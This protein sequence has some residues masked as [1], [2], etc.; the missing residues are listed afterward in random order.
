M[1]VIRKTFYYHQWREGKKLKK[2]LYYLETLPP[3]WKS[4]I[5]G[6]LVEYMPDVS[7]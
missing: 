6:R 3:K 2:A 5:K 7:F 4:Y 1:S